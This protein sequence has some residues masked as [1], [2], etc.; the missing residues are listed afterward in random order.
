MI[1]AWI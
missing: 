1:T